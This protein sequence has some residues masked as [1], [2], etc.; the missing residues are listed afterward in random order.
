MSFL[1][2]IFGG[3]DQT[4]TTTNT[5]WGPIQ[6][7][8]L[9][10]LSQLSNMSGSRSYYPG[11]QVAGFTPAQ[12]QGFDYLTGAAGNIGDYANMFGNS[13]STY[14]SP[15]FMDPNANPYM[16]D[17]VNSAI[18]PLT[19]NFTQS[20]LPSL[21]G[22]DR[23]T[24]GGTYGSSRS[25]IA[26]GLAANNLENAVGDVTS[27][28][29]TDLYGQ[30]IGAQQRAMALT[31]TLANLFQMPG[32]IMTGIG[33]MQQ[34]QAQNEIN[35]NMNAYNYNRDQ[36]WNDIMSILAASSGMPYGTTT[37]TQQGNGP[38]AGML[39]TGLM[40]YGLYNNFGSDPYGT[41]SNFGSGGIDPM[42][43]MMMG[44]L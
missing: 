23:L 11:Q 27:R 2:D 31:P 38:W 36:P 5:P 34:N 16:S 9:D 6:P 8:I 33:G 28:M 44:G 21:R 14:L 7:Y 26:Q 37:G 10:S 35:A 19:E 25:G 42:L 41:N 12:M 13:L 20:I 39:G 22:G 24:G 29:Y 30:N 32:Q 15:D 40:G 4:T 43:W 17:Y 3:G 18:R 1:T